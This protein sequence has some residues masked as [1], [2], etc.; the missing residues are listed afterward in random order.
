MGKP[1]R[2][3]FRFLMIK[4]RLPAPSMTEKDIAR[5]YSKVREGRVDE[6]WEWKDH[7]DRQGYGHIGIGGKYTKGGRIYRAHR[8]ALYLDKNLW[9]EDAMHTCD[10][11]CCCNPK[12]LVAG[13]HAENMEDMHKKK[14]SKGGNGGMFGQ[15]NGMSKLTPEV[16]NEIR[17]RYAIGKESQSELGKIFGVS[18]TQIGRIVRNER[19][20]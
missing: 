1:E 3:E 7:L 18:Q 4:T 2:K 16:V 8:I 15:R 17:I 5:F 13:T 10:N 19:W 9:P 20:K 12:H 14:R 6:C 11:P